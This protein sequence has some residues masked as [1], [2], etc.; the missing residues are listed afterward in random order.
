VA[1]LP[2]K[3]LNT[4]KQWTDAI[5]FFNYKQKSFT[6]QYRKGKYYVGFAIIYVQEKGRKF[7][8]WQ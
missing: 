8:L 2:F 6:W 7:H 4:K 3:S 1:L 5:A